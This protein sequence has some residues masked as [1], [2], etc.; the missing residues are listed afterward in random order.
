M[1]KVGFEPTL[2]YGNC[3]LNAARLPVSPLRQAHTE[4]SLNTKRSTSLFWAGVQN[5]PA[6]KLGQG[7]ILACREKLRC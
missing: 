2:P 7:Q 4:Q 3:A 1:P 5:V 6:N